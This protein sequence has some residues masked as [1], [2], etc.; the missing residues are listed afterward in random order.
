MKERDLLNVV[1]AMLDRFGWRWWHIPAPMKFAGKEKGWIPA[2]EGAGLPD[3]I[4]MHTDPPRL[5][6]M[7]LKGDE[8]GPGTLSDAQME[9]LKLAKV[10]AESCGALDEH[11]RD[12]AYWPDDQVIGVFAVW[13]DDLDRVEQMLR[14][15]VVA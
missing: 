8:H 6:L 7:E 5:I 11:Y 13:P 2:R 14:S 1:T 9:F 12:G 4:A 10:V 3:I 15:R